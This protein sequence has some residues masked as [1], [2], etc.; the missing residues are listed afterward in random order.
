MEKSW[1][2]FWPTQYLEGE[3]KNTGDIKVPGED[4]LSKISLVCMAVLINE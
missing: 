3:I 2:T 1:Q 4:G